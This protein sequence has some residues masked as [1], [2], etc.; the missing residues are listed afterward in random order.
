[1]KEITT[2]YTPNN[3]VFSLYS[4][5]GYIRP[6]CYAYL[7]IAKIGDDVGQ[8]WHWMVHEHMG[9]FLDVNLYTS[10]YWEKA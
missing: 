1:M 2:T 5:M 3:I 10:I 9:R 6:N 7:L 4:I 8:T